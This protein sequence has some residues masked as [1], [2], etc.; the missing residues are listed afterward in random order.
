MRRVCSS[1]LASSL[2]HHKGK[3]WPWML[4]TSASSWKSSAMASFEFS[5]M[6][7]T[8]AAM[9]PAPLPPAP[10]SAPT[11]STVE[12]ASMSYLVGEK[13]ILIYLGLHKI[14]LDGVHKLKMLLILFQLGTCLLT[15]LH[16][17]VQNQVRTS[18]DNTRMNILS[19][20]KV[21]KM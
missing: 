3:C 14:L 17:N 11:T 16:G 12:V 6:L 19:T 15:C 2:L 4:P 1:I 20:I 5:M 7:F 21:R 13:S 18:F 10:P 8:L 9:S